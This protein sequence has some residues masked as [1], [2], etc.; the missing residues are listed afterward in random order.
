MVRADIHSLQVSATVSLPYPIINLVGAIYIPT[1]DA[2]VES[3]LAQNDG[4]STNLA[5]Q[6]PPYDLS[7]SHAEKSSYELGKLL[8]L[9]G[10]AWTVIR[11]PQFSQWE[12]WLNRIALLPYPDP[13]LQF[14]PKA[15]DASENGL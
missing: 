12:V 2:R 7:A 8:I 11:H 1:K 13:R 14:F 15:V 5:Q 6:S 4:A 9:S 10:A 3:N